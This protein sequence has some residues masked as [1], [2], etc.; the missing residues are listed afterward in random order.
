MT[1]VVEDEVGEERERR[2]KKAG[3]V[4]V[5]AG[6]RRRRR[7]EDYKRTVNAAELLHIHEDRAFRIVWKRQQVVGR[8]EGGKEVEN[9]GKLGE[10]NVRRTRHDRTTVARDRE[11]LANG[12]L[13]GG[14]GSL[15]LEEGVDHEKVAGGLEL[16][17]AKASEGVIG[18]DVATLAN[19][20]AR[21]QEKVLAASKSRGEGKR[22]KEGEGEQEEE[23]VPRRLGDGVAHRHDEESGKEG[24]TEH[25]APVEPADTGNVLDMVEN[26]RRNGTE[27][28]TKRS[29]QGGG[30]SVPSTKVQRGC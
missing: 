27:H 7:Q 10:R 15:F 26:E 30:E 14:D 22:R 8:G 18:V 12:R 11:Q 13:A 29:L 24:R 21:G 5:L 16:G 23:C 1:I 6:K 19:E 9:E 17:V 20:P 4:S 25:Q 28:D 3:K 2:A